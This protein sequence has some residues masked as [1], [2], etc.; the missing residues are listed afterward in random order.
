MKSGER[1]HIRTQEGH[2]DGRMVDISAD[3]D[4]I[5]QVTWCVSRLRRL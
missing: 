3:F 1:S 5:M 4:V 2:R